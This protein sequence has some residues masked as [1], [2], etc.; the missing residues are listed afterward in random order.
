MGDL[1]ILSGDVFKSVL[2]M[3]Y[4][5]MDKNVSLVLG[6]R[7]VFLFVR[8]VSVMVSIIFPLLVTKLRYIIWI[9]AWVV[10]LCKMV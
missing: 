5:F 9:R 8:T 1:P 6:T 10:A 3:I 2:K 4:R 7:F